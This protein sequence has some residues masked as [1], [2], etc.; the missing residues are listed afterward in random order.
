MGDVL[1]LMVLT[2][3]KIIMFDSAK[4]ELLMTQIDLGDP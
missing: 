1:N 3:S 4:S 2:S